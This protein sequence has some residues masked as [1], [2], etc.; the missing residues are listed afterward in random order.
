MI[1]DPR[2]VDLVMSPHARVLS[3]DN[4]KAYCEIEIGIMPTTIS[5]LKAFAS[6]LQGIT[7]VLGH[8]LRR[9]SECA[10]RNMGAAPAAGRLLRPLHDRSLHWRD[11]AMVRIRT[12]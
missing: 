4:R 5:S 10:R 7:A 2:I 12:G 8:H 6:Y 11:A 3:I 9:D 1:Y